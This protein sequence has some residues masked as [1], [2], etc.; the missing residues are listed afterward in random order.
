M[1]TRIPD[2]ARPAEPGKRRILLVANEALG[3]AGLRDV[4]GLRIDGEPPL[5][6]RVVAPALNSRLRH[7]MSDDDGARRSA[8]LR[9][10]ATLQGLWA[11]GVEAEGMVGDADPLL[12]IADGLHKFEAEQIVIATRPEGRSDWLTRGLVVRARQRFDRPVV[13]VVGEPSD[14]S[15]HSEPTKGPRVRGAN[16]PVAGRPQG[17]NA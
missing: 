2:T 13:L 3:Q 12:A 17:V 14:E 16:A 5:E 8:A 7:W 15:A 1:T 10:E 6:V 11:A 4:A 9:L